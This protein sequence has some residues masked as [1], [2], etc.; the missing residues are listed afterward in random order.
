MQRKLGDNQGEAGATRSLLGPVII[1][2]SAVAHCALLGY[3]ALSP[4]VPEPAAP[5]TER[6]QVQ[7]FEHDEAK[8]TWSM[9]GTRWALVARDKLAP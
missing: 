7:V 5:K 1:T 9:L 4:A 6:V 3:A 2:I 8:D